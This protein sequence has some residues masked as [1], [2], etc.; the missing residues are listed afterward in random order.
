MKILQSGEIR[1]KGSKQVFYWQ[2]VEEDGLPT[3]TE[4]MD[5]PF[6]R[7]IVEPPPTITVRHPDEIVDK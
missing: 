3:K 7:E 2:L 1:H 5:H 6:C 4:G